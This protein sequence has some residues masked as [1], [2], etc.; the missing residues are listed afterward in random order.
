MVIL[1]LLSSFILTNPI[2]RYIILVLS[3]ICAFVQMILTI[4]N[5]K[6][7]YEKYLTEKFS[8]RIVK[9]EEL[10]LP[11]AKN[12]IIEKESTK[13]SDKCRAAEN[14]AALWRWLAFLS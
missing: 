12:I 13:K 3:I 2:E 11:N 9:K 10:E 4:I 5:V 8:Q 1:S 6:I 7:R 14:L